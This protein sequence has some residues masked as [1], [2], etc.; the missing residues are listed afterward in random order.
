MV[1]KGARAEKY[2]LDH[3]FELR[4][5]KIYKF[6]QVCLTFNAFCCVPFLHKRN[7]R[8]NVTN[9]PSYDPDRLTARPIAR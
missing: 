3:N 2:T 9:V 6:Y 4:A 8:E 5:Y 1:L 7:V